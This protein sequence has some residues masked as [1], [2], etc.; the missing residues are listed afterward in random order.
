MDDAPLISNLPEG[1]TKVILTG[2]PPEHWRTPRQGDQLTVHYIATLA[3]D[4]SEFDSSRK[5][6][7]PD[8][9]TLGAGQVIKGWDIGVATMRKGE[10][11]KF[12]FSAEFAYGDDGIA[13]K[14]PPKASLVF[15]IELVSWISKDDLFQDEGVFRN[16]LEEGEGWEMPKTEDHVLI[17]YSVAD[18]NGDVIAERADFEMKLGSGVLGPISKAVD[19]ALLEMKQQER[20]SLVCS[21]EYSYGNSTP[22]GVTIDLLLLAIYETEDVSPDK[23]GSVIKKQVQRGIDYHRP[24]DASKV[25]LTVETVMDGTSALAGFDGPKTLEFIAGNGEVCDAL[26]F[27]VIAMSKEEKAVVTCTKPEMWCG[28]PVGQTS[29]ET[30]QVTLTLQLTNFDKGKDASRMSEHDKCTLGAERKTVGSSLFKKGRYY[31]AAQR[32]KGVIDLYSYIDNFSEVNKKR[33][34]DLKKV[35]ELNMAACMLKTK[36]YGGAKEA[37]NKVLSEERD[38]IKALYRRAQAQFHRSEYSEATQDIQRLLDID[39]GNTEAKSLL[40]QVRSAQ[41]VADKQATKMYANMFR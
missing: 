35:C 16:I 38:N 41:R 1:I 14:I 12:T 37:C 13:P 22:D 15:E 2:A 8:T 10:I 24:T 28:D 3:E 30:G 21:K 23:D 7:E 39:S 29:G 17:T 9:F 31:L 27:A 11:A 40:S 6:G 20:V 33:A 26:E 5:R 25:K 4:G 32:F 18:I 36:D 19:K 34:Q